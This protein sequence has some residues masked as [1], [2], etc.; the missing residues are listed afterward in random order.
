MKH[1][2]NVFAPPP[3]MEKIYTL[4][5]SVKCTLYID[6]PIFP[7]QIISGYLSYFKCRL[8]DPPFYGYHCIF[9]IFRLVINNGVE[10]CQSVYHLHVHVLGGRQLTWPPG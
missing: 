6:K 7:F 5:C 9:V 10:G 4:P 1:E 3:F 2:T 8:P